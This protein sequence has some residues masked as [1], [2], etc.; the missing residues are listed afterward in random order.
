[1]DREERAAELQQMIDNAR[2]G[3]DRY[4]PNLD[5][6]GKN[7]M[8][9]MDEQLL[10]NLQ[11]RGKSSIFIP[12]ISSVALKIYTSIVTTYFTNPDFATVSPDDP[13][14]SLAAE[15]AEAIQNAL[16]YYE[17][18][19]HFNLFPVISKEILNASIYYL[20][21]V[22]AYWHG[23]APRIDSIKLRDIWFDPTATNL[24]DCQYIVHRMFISRQQ[25]EKLHKNFKS[26]KRFDASDLQSTSDVSAYNAAQPNRYQLI[27]LF[28]VYERTDNAEE[29]QVSTMAGETLIRDELELKDGLPIFCGYLI[30]PFVKAEEYDAVE[31]YG[32][33]PVEFILPLQ[34]EMNQTRNQQLD[35]IR[36]GL[37]PRFLSQHGTGINP[38]ALL[39][40]NRVLQA[41]DITHVKELTPPD[42][43]QAEGSISQTQLDAQDVSAVTPY[44]TGTSG[45][46]GNETA[47][48]TAILTQEANQRLSVY[49]QSFNETFI[50]PMMMH[51]VKLVWRYADTR[52]F[53]G[54][55][56]SRDVDPDLFVHVNTGIG[57][58]NP[59]TRI[60]QMR[61]AI[62][63]LM[64]LGQP[65]GV[66]RL[67]K[68]MLG[69][70]G[71]NNAGELLDEQTFNGANAIPDINTGALPA[72]AG[73][74]NVGGGAGV[75]GD[76]GKPDLGNIP[77]ILSG[78]ISNPV[79]FDRG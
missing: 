74:G 22:K 36:L 69:L 1:M 49:T 41:A 64:K 11:R 35:A 33:S 59:V 61:E 38:F 66:I 40:N 65:Q 54:T 42:A 67:S 58:T 16:R 53:E 13:E 29:W 5:L 70:L 48:G 57:A 78:T 4:K 45:S 21:A 44:N 31:M 63:L 71:I 55:R 25:A 14:D 56:L 51:V 2:Q 28:D 24:K 9:E 39:G 52:H 68:T 73:G 10:D 26:F 72:G 23:N 7:Y 27:E 30:P 75:T 15:A 20:V 3:F 43:R 8:C 62:Q 60:N 18:H 19:K 12:L 47:T 79:T 50:V 46:V 77:S 6:L 76:D 32:Q 17:R 34:A 37:E